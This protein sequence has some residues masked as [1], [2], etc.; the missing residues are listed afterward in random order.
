MHACFGQLSPSGFA[1]GR[2]LALPRRN[3]R[4]RS[5]RVSLSRQPS[6][7]ANPSAA[8]RPGDLSPNASNAHDKAREIEKVRAE[9]ARAFR[10]LQ[11]GPKI[12]L[13]QI[14]RR[15]AGHAIFMRNERAIDLARYCTDMM[16]KGEDFATVWQ[17][18]LKRHPLIDEIPRQTREGNQNLL[19]VRLITGERL[20]FDADAKRFSVR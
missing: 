12:D 7:T 15:A 1:K 6:Q 2:R 17:R 13:D 4:L 20:V 19:E 10:E 5:A 14:R 18:R 11:D 8:S 3:Q 9:L 16:Q